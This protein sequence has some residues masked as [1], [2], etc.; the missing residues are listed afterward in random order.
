MGVLTNAVPRGHRYH[1]LKR[2][3]ELLELH[4][5]LDG[6]FLDVGCGT[7]WLV[8]AWA[9][10][11]SVGA[12]VW[13]SQ[14][15][16]P[17][18]PYVLA[19]TARIPFAD[20]SFS[21][22][23]VVAALGAFPPSQLAAVCVELRRVLKPGGVAVI[24]VSANHRIADRVAIHRLRSGFE[25]QSFDVDELRDTFEVSGFGVDRV[26]RRGGSVTVAVE[27]LDT[28]ARPMTR[29]NVGRRL[30]SRIGELDRRTMSTVSPKG[31]YAYLV[32]RAD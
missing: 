27:W 2:A 1:Q 22:L 6:D 11:R 17:R 19:D 16:D 15:W 9:P 20:S 29:F 23:G 7:G 18:S 24:L 10:G 26:E 13:R 28:L 30:R 4:A 5:A 21:A 25:W 3:A 32:C 31:R 8:E 14:H 12:D